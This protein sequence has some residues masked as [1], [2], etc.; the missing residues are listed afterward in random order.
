VV[1]GHVPFVGQV[2]LQVVGHPLGPLLQVPRSR[3]VIILVKATGVISLGQGR[4]VPYF[5]KV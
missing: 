1:H 3:P 2:L 5:K 4:D